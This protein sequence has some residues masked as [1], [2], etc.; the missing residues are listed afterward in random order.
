MADG[1]KRESTVRDGGTGGMGSA[2]TGGTTR[3]GGDLGGTKGASGGDGDLGPLTGGAGGGAGELGAAMGAGSG[4]PRGGMGGLGGTGGID[5]DAIRD[6]T[7]AQ[8]A[9]DVG[10]GDK[11]P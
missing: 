8:D 2:P 3:R 11:E 1:E 4:D 6:A 9:K 10:P 5:K 7:R